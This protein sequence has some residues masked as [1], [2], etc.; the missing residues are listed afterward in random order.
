[1]SH[2]QPDTTLPK[3]PKVKIYRASLT[4]TSTNAP[5]TTIYQNTLGEIVWTR[6]G[7]GEYAGT[8]AGTFTANKTFLMCKINSFSG[9]FQHLSRLSAN[10]I[11]METGQNV[12]YADGIMNNTM[13]E[14]LVY[15]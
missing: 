14:I 13:I 12:T 11:Q 1:M 3:E 8:L 9:L 7:V 4:Q 5:V 10:A 15:E 6:T 2:I